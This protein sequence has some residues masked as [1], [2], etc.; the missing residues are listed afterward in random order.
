MLR[1]NK[2]SFLLQK[3]EIIFFSF[4][5]FISLQL[6]QTKTTVNDKTRCI[7]PICANSHQYIE[8]LDN[9]NQKITCDST[10]NNNNNNINNKED[11]FGAKNINKNT[12]SE[13]ELI[14]RFAIPIVSKSQT[15]GKCD[16]KLDSL[17]EMKRFSSY[18]DVVLELKQKF[19]SCDT[20]NTISK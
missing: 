3:I 4:Y 11:I 9:E 12:V 10:H 2:I 20:L 17:Y 15:L 13:K 14:T 8:P 18:G 7:C 16:S 19:S 1:I 5:L 6:T